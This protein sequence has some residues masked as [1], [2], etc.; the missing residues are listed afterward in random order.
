MAVTPPQ[1][2]FQSLQP[3]LLLGQFGRLWQ[4]PKKPGDTVQRT[5]TRQPKKRD[6]R[7]AAAVATVT[8]TLCRRLGDLLLSHEPCEADKIVPILRVE[9]PRLGGLKRH[10]N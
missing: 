2:L 7:M 6:A 8:L 10:A 9:K 4:T 1:P 5:H 3:H